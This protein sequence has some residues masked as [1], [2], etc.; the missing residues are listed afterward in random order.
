M[1]ANDS[2]PYISCLNKLLEQYSNT[3]QHSINKKTYSC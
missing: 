1:T 3:Y 2:K